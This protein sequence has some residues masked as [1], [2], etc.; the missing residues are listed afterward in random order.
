[1]SKLSETQYLNNL[2][3]YTEGKTYINLIGLL[4]CRLEILKTS[5]LTAEGLEVQKIQGQAKEITHL[6][7]SL[8][9]KPMTQQ[10]TG[11]FN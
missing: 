2:R 7:K 10:H 4:N 11:A 5:L 8:T 6:L 1:M 9:R 3:S